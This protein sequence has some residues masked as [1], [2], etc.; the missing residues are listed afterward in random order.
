MKKSDPPDDLAEKQS[1]L[2]DIIREAADQ[3]ASGEVLVAFS[4]GVDSS[5]L[6]L[7]SVRT[8]GPKR[9]TAV[10]ATAPTLM[11]DEEEA[12]RLFAK[13][14][15][16]RHV[17]VSTG[18]CEDSSFT[19]NPKNRCY[20][21]KRIRYGLLC[22]MAEEKGGAVVFDGAQADDDPLERPGMRAVEE[23]GVRTPLR[24]AGVGKEDIRRLL[25]DAG[26][27]DLAHKAA[28]PCLATRIPTGKPI[29]AGA[30]RMI[31][32]GEAF[33][34]ECGLKTVRLRHDGPTARIETDRDGMSII[35][36]DHGL[37]TRVSDRLKS[38]GY[39]QVTLDLDEYG[40]GK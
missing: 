20:I 7:E 12:A 9:V 39:E 15:N 23:L 38:L 13:S 40:R 17:V 33:L 14:L 18:E 36:S 27:I 3:T 32:M 24:E 8:L 10:T 31:G 26:F 16:I 19:S 35:L 30:L 21:C 28:Q 4:G 6:L 34:K 22:E 2:R 25:V 37:R 29:T 11:D 1:R 5:L